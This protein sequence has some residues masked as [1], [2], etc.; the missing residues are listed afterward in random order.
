MRYAADI[1]SVLRTIQEMSQNR[2]NGRPRSIGSTR[3]QSGTEKHM[4]TKGIAAKSSDISDGRFIFIFTSDLRLFDNLEA[5]VM[6]CP[7]FTIRG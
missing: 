4:A 7:Y 3:S 1:Q 2:L 6:V 5:D